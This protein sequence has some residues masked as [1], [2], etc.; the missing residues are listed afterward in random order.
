MRK[1]VEIYFGTNDPCPTAFD[2]LEIVEEDGSTA[3]LLANG[4]TRDERIE[5][6]RLEKSLGRML[7]EQAPGSAK[8]LLDLYKK[9]YDFRKART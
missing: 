2:D 8:R 3:T 6:N 1:D 7:E 9:L 5:C 4:L